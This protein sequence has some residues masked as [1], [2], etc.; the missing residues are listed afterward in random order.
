MG[1]I[2]ASFVGLSSTAV[3]GNDDD[4]NS[5]FKWPDVQQM[6]G[7]EYL[8]KPAVNGF[9]WKN[10]G[11]ETDI[12]QI[13]S[14]ALAPDPIKLPGNITL[15]FAGGLHSSLTAPL[16]AD[17]KVEKKVLFWIEVPCIE[18]V[19]S[20]SYDD[21]CQ[22]ISTM[23]CPPVF[24]KYGIP[25]QCPVKAGNYKANHA[26]LY[27]NPKGIPS[28]AED[29]EYRATITVRQGT[30]QVICLSVQLSLG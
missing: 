28:W 1:S 3:F 30:R 7:S 6:P 13:D 24:M 19:G 2:L 25:C 23:G 26:E 20:C 29:G 18:N 10:C 15:S 5:V 12:G 14:L 16:S 27:L 9:S 21:I 8:I 22:I 17:V 11:Q 4:M